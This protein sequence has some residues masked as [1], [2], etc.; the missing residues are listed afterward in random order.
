M[1]CCTFMFGVSGVSDGVALS[2]PAVFPGLL[3]I[4]PT[5]HLPQS[6]GS[7][8]SLREMRRP[9]RRGS[10]EMHKTAFRNSKMK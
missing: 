4:L 2:S 10:V 5:E 3:L 9:S 7:F 1:L 6:M 8:L